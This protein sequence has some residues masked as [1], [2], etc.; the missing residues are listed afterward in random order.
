MFD[1]EKYSAERL[2]RNGRGYQIF[3]ERMEPVYIYISSK[4][5]IMSITGAKQQA[6]NDQ[7]AAQWNSISQRIE[8]EPSHDSKH[9]NSVH[10]HV[11]KENNI[12]NEVWKT[13]TSSSNNA[14]KGYI[15]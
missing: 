15:M 13:S 8:G 3:S 1:K 12:A 10:H 2:A 11:L 4:E 7:Y 6:T 5:N 9:E 14:E